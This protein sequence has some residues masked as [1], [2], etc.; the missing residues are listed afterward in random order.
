MAHNLLTEP[1]IRF[2]TS[3]GLERGSLPE[4]YAALMADRVESFPALRAHQ[5]PA[6]HM[7]LAQLGAIACHRE[8][9]SEPP[10]DAGAWQK[11]ICRL[12]REAFPADE[13]W[14]LVVDNWSKP[15]FLQPPVPEGV[16]LKDEPIIAPDALDMLITSR[17]HDLKQAVASASE[18]DDWLFALVSLQTMEGYGGGQGKLQGIVRMSNAYASRFHISLSPLDEKSRT[19]SATSG[20]KLRRDIWRMLQSRSALKKRFPVACDSES[21]IALTWIVEW[22]EA[23]P[24]NISDLDIWFIEVCRRIR[25]SKNDRVV[26]ARTGGSKGKRISPL[27]NPESEK[28]SFLAT[29]DFWAPLNRANGVPFHLNADNS[30]GYEVVVKLLGEDWELP[31]S[32]VLDPSEIDARKNWLLVLAAVAHGQNETGGFKFRVIPLKGRV[33]RGLGPKR[34][35]LHQLATEQISEIKKIKAVLTDAMGIFGRG[36]IY[37]SEIPKDNRNKE[38]E[39]QC[40]RA[41]PYRDRLDDVADR[42]FFEA[43]WKRFEA[44][45]HGDTDDAEAARRAFLL[46]LIDTARDLLEEGLANIPCPSIRRPRAEARARR[47]FRSQLRGDK[48]GFPGLLDNAKPDEPEMTDAA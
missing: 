14:C 24:L 11:I 48:T 47:W 26:T 43:L 20:G 13:P 1:L 23:Q 3:D 32:T 37:W 25:L 19:D 2:E 40:K 9:L 36:G 44:E 16:T 22:P 29:G 42:E 31:F 46:P 4:V 41:H 34:K 12:T 35:E 45:Q 7:F 30:M 5:E 38:G 6:W 21:G 33:A 39:R 27:L 17:N 10:A 28:K 15:A 8:G 18:A